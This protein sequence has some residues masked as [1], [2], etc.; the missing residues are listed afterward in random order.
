M[1]KVIPRFGIGGNG[2][3]FFFVTLA[4]ALVT[5]WVFADPK[6]AI[7]N[8]YPFP[9]LFVA[10]WLILSIAWFA[11]NFELSLFTWVPERQPLRGV[12]ITA[13]SF[14]LVYV[15]YLVLNVGWGAINPNF[16][17]TSPTGYVLS[18]FFVLI[19]FFIWVMV[20]GLAFGHW[21][22]ADAGL[23]QPALGLAEWFLGFFLTMVFYLGLVY[24]AL[25]HPKHALL[26]FFTMTGW[27]YS[28]IVG[29]IVVWILWGNWPI[30][31]ISKNRAVRAIGTG[32]IAFIVGTIWYFIALRLLKGWLLPEDIQAQMAKAAPTLINYYAAELG[33]CFNAAALFL[34]LF[35]ANWPT[36][37]SELTNLIIRTI[38][39][40]VSGIIIFLIFMNGFGVVVLHEQAP[41]LVVGNW[42]GDP[43]NFMDWWI[44]IFLV[45][46][47]YFGNWPLMKKVEE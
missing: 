28:C 9:F 46:G 12:I 30:T 11:F 42:G 14:L 35:F 8:A 19:G 38:I 47:V 3:I 1:E 26:G 31:K 4:I 41:T 32:L 20:C 6:W 18:S 29:M 24:P 2:V 15:A 40:L 27:W 23:K 36:K 21:P 37:F 10:V 25:V 5:W 45:V 22:F 39:C 17:P 44:A 7:V 43:L 33:V 16:S 13:F 34:F